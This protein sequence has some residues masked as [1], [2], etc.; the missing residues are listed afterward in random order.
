LLCKQKEWIMTQVGDRRRP[1]ELSDHEAA[2]RKPLP[3]DSF[4]GAMYDKVHIDVER[5]GRVAKVRR[6]NGNQ[7]KEKEENDKATHTCGTT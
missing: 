3:P 2:L 4:I 1:K 6:I 5:E 7:E